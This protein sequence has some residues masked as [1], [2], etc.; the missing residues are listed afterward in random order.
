MH[1][2]SYLITYRESGSRDRLDNLLAVLAWLAQWPSIEV[3]I[4]EQDDVPRLDASLP[5]AGAVLRFAYNPGLFNKAWGLNVALRFARGSVLAIGD[6]DVIAPH[7]FALA[8]QRCREVAAVKPYRTIVDLTPEQS[9]RVRAGEWS[10]LPERP[11]AAPPS[12]EGQGEY[13]VFGGGL[14][15]I[16]REWLL[17]LGGFDERF[18]GW[19]GEDDAMTQKLRRAA[20]PTEELDGP[21]AL[22]LWHPRAPKTTFGQPHYTDNRRL[23][24]DYHGYSAAEFA[25]LC[26]VQRQL[27][28]HLNKYRPEDGPTTP[29]LIPAS[30]A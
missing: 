21:P 22:H 6:A 4:I 25:R 3:V 28:G 23:L 19:G 12:R 9:A 8:A 29:P 27:M 13:I 2:L 18:R 15:L 17:R 11:A 5:C 7:T 30:S 1:D 10:W 14:F 26:E 16:Q 24:D 20:V